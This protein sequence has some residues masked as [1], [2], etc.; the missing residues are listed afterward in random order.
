MG[1]A[2]R[3]GQAGDQPSRRLRGKGS[4]RSNRPKRCSPPATP[5][6]FGDGPRDDGRSRRSWNKGRGLDVEPQR[7]CIGLNECIHRKQVEGL[8]YACGDEPRF[9]ASHEFGGVPTP[10]QHTHDRSS[11]IGGGPGGTEF[12]AQCAEQGH[13]VRLWE[14]NGSLGGALSIASLRKGQRPSTDVGSTYQLG[15]ARRVVVDVRLGHAATADDV[16]QRPEPTWSVVATGAT[17]RIPPTPGVESDR[18]HTRRAAAL[19][20]EALLG[21]RIALDLRGRRARAVRGH[22]SPRRSWA[23]TLLVYQT[24]SPSPLVGKYWEGRWHAGPTDR[25]WCRVRADGP[26]HKT[27]QRTRTVSRCIWRRALGRGV[28]A[29]GPVRFGS[30]RRRLDPE[31]LALTAS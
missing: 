10:H 20:G 6:S 2:V 19:R 13:T 22:R 5:T 25:P 16:E 23:R 27:H 15:A 9:R 3:A 26:S 29:I 31:Q 7:P 12:A 24:T 8:R 14:R 21:R 11:W 17:P 30:A 28:G 4:H 1:G 18:V